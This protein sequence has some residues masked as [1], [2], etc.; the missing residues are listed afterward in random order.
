MKLLYKKS[1][2]TPKSNGCVVQ[3]KRRNKKSKTK[4]IDE[5]NKSKRVV[6]S[7]GSAKL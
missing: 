5:Q 3:G 6:R 4:E 7:S 1:R 2:G